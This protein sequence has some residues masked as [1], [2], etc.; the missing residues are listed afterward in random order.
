[1]KKIKENKRNTAIPGKPMNDLEFKS[2]IKE[3]EKGPFL[4]EVE[5]TKDFDEWRKQ[6]KKK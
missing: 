3:G 6:L 1:M 4:T 5:Y 2:F